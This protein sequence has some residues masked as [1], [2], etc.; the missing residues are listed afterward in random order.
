MVIL[1]YY[2]M[3]VSF[4]LVFIYRCGDRYRLLLRKKGFGVA[5]TLS[6]SSEEV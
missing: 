1:E 4:A 6:K 3:K 2:L 5:Y